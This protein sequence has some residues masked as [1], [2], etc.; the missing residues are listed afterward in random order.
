MSL[1]SVFLLQ[2]TVHRAIFVLQKIGKDK[3]KE[4]DQKNI[5]IKSK[6]GVYQ[7]QN[8]K[9]IIN[10]FDIPT[11]VYKDIEGRKV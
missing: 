9:F 4:K 5:P 3:W 1:T 10:R 11:V 6:L 2:F 7:P 8:L